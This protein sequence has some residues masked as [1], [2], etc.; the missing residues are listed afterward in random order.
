MNEIEYSRYDETK[1][2]IWGMEFDETRKVP[3]SN[4]NHVITENYLTSADGNTYTVLATMSNQAHA[5]LSGS[6]YAAW[7]FLKQFSRNEDG[8]I[9][10]T[11]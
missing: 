1:N 7:D 5:V 6:S 10:I 3:T 9:T 2:A 4:P 8:S 11:E